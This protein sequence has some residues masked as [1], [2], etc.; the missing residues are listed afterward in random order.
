[1]KQ[2]LNGVR[3]LDFGRYIAGPY[4]AMMLG[5]LGADVIRIERVDGGD[6]RYNQYPINE[7]GIGASFLQMNRNKKGITLNPLKPAAS[8]ILK[9]LIKTADVVVV[10]LPFD[11]LK[12]MGLDYE[13]LT[14]IKEDIILTN[15]SAFGEHGP[16]KNKIGLDG[17]GQA[18]SGAAYLSGEDGKPMKSFASWVDV[19]SGTLAAYGTMAALFHHRMT[20]EGQQVS[21][22]LFSSGVAG[23]SWL[24]TEQAAVGVDRIA[25]GSMI[26]SGGPGDFYQTRDGWIVLQILGEPLFKR[27]CELMDKPEW[28]TDERFKDDVSRA[29]HGDYLSEETQK[30]ITQYERAELLEILEK[31]RIPAGPI[32][33]PQQVLDDPHADETKMFSEVDYPGL[34]KPARIFNHPVKFSNSE[35][36]IRE[37]APLLGEH[38]DSVLNEL[39]F[40]AEEIQAFREARVV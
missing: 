27:L 13:S 31:A 6:D 38:T 18:M 3:V 33:S 14:K 12:Q 8:E 5:D 4:C 10:N 35:T 15:V 23:L 28:L 17:I 32:L 16:Y 2:I 11:T 21:S 37:R 36:T 20:S 9:R 1:M 26:Q 24:H 25:K 22:D 19:M 30:W 7:E 40:S 29:E 39:E 34:T